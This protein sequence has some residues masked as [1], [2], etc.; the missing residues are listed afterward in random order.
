MLTK[1]LY[2]TVSY[3]YYHSQFTGFDTQTYTRSAWDNRH[4]ISLTGGYLFGKN[5][6]WE[7]AAKW[8]FLGPNPYTPFDTLASIANYLALG[9]GV[10]DYSRVNTLQSGSFSQ[11]DFRLDKKWF[12]KKWSLNVFLD[13]QN[14][15]NQK[16]PGIPNFTL[17]RDAQTGQ[18][19]QPYLPEIVGLESGN[20][21]PSIGLRIKI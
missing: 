12:F 9:E 19:I 17:K 4:L 14:L 1:R 7:I 16:N 10:F 18:F 11:V 3:T 21:I 15:L 20:L 2:G 6:S 13:I 8:R 5:K